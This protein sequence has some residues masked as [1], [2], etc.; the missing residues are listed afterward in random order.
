MKILP[1]FRKSHRLLVLGCISLMFDFIGIQAWKLSDANQLLIVAVIV[2]S[3]FITILL[4]TM[5]YTCAIEEST[6][7]K[8][9]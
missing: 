6:G 7:D 8:N 1:G 9:D 3:L 4:W 2:L 5:A